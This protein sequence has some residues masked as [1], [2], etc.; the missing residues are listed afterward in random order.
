M[1]CDIYAY[2]EQRPRGTHTWEHQ[3]DI[4]VFDWRSYRLFGWLGDVR[5]ESAVPPI[6][7]YRGLPADVSNH[8]RRDREVWE[9]DGYGV[10][11]VAV[12]EL[13][14]F[15]YDA[16][17]EDRYVNTDGRGITVGPGEGT[18]TTYREFLGP[19]FFEELAQLAGLERQRETRVVFWFDS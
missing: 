10:S 19:A 18:L 16:T 13:L 6:A 2:V 12:T 4:K 9:P 1:G 14:E 3:A 7:A 5:N 17:F 8:V 11:W 15:D